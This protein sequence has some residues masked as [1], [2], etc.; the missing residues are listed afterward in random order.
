MAIDVNDASRLDLLLRLADAAKR[1]GQLDRARILHL[2]AIALARRTGDA[3][4]LA[5]AGY[6]GKCLYGR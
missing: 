6:L 1:C 3:R 4:S 2:E 5:L